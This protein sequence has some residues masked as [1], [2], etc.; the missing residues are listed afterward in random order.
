MKRQLLELRHFPNQGKVIVLY[1]QPG[2]ETHILNLLRGREVSLSAVQIFHLSQVTEC[3]QFMPCIPPPSL[4]FFH[5][6]A[7]RHPAQGL[8]RIG[9]QRRVYFDFFQFHIAFLLRYIFKPHLDRPLSSSSMLHRRAACSVLCTF[10]FSTA[11][12]L[13]SPVPLSSW[14]ESGYGLHQTA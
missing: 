8:G 11:S 14:A 3:L 12:R 6:K 7:L 2:R 9:K 1:H 10:P 4:I 5:I 13:I